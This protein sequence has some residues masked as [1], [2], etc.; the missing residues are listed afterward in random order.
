MD[1]V[2]P[3]DFDRVGKALVD[4]FGISPLDAANRLRSARPCIVVGNDLAASPTLQAALLTLVNLTPRIF[5]AGAIVSAP[6]NVLS[7]VPSINT[8]Y[9]TLREAVAAHGGVEGIDSLGP[10]RIVVG[11]NGRGPGLRLTFDG[12]AA[13][14]GPASWSE[15]MPQRERCVLAGVAGAAMALGELFF[16]A[17]GLSVEATE[18]E[19]GVSLWSP[20]AGED[21]LDGPGP[22][23]EFLPG[24]AWLLG[25]GHLGQG[26]VWALS[27]LPYEE[28][29]KM[30]LLLQ[31]FDR[32]VL[33]NIGT[34]VLTSISDVGARKTLVCAK[35]LR[36]R[37]FDPGLIDR[38]FDDRSPRSNTEPALAMCGFD[39]QGP[40]EV[41][42][43]V[44]FD[45]VVVCGVGGTASDFDELQLHTLP[46]H[47]VNA[48]DVW[49]KRARAG[50]SEALAA[51][52]P[53]YRAYRETHR[54]GEV[55][56]AGLSVAAPFVGA[57]AGALAWAEVLRELHGG[58]RCGFV[59][60][61]LRALEERR[62]RF[63]PGDAP[64]PRYARPCLNVA[65][66]SGVPIVLAP[67]MTY[68]N[69]R[70]V[71]PEL[72]QR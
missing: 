20:H 31:D 8:P 13:R 29:G 38:P 69:G 14:V 16:L 45:R 11:I 15:A 33:G 26:L 72:D 28:P 61:P 3:D 62:V 58:A 55:E 9:A 2:H 53:F 21:S 60:L 43:R 24:E 23:V 36:A 7:V 4:R 37:G 40:R 71:G 18:R 42:D 51:G 56:L 67:G 47:K 1:R 68:P 30:D 34:Q 12:W 50:G 54:C 70:S 5:K 6:S 63:S 57:M 19:V 32:V 59:E 10:N 25:L 35:F 39:G 44:N 27:L 41:L 66:R 17:A 22:A 52:N 65:S 48:S 49:P 64:R 46:F